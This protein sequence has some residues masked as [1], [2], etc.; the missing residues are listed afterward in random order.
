MLLCKK[1]RTVVVNLYDSSSDSHWLVDLTAVLQMY[2][3]N[4]IN[5]VLTKAEGC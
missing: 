4:E 1:E 2:N 5:V 3:A